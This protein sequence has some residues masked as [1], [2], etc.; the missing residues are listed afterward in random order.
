MSLAEQVPLAQVP[1]NPP[2]MLPLIENVC[3]VPVPVEEFCEI[4]SV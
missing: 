2:V 1:G 4:E 3:A